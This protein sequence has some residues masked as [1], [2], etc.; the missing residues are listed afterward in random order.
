MDWNNAMLSTTYPSPMQRLFRGRYEQK[1]LLDYFAA[2]DQW[3]ELLCRFFFL[4]PCGSSTQLARSSS[5]N[6]MFADLVVGK[7][8]SSLVL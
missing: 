6:T 1:I 3:E 5:A 8:R 7:S 4:Q 2:A